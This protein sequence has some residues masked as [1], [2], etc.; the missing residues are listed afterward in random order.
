MTKNIYIIL[1]LLMTIIVSAQE[2]DTISTDSLFVVGVNWQ[3]LDDSG[4]DYRASITIDLNY[5]EFMNPVNKF[6]IVER[7]EF[8][9]YFLSTLDLSNYIGSVNSYVDENGDVQELIVLNYFIE[10]LDECVGD[11]CKDV[12]RAGYYGLPFYIQEASFQCDVNDNDKGGWYYKASYSDNDRVSFTRPSYEGITDPVLTVETAETPLGFI[13]YPAEIVRFNNIPVTCK[14]MTTTQ[15]SK[16]SFILEPN[17]LYRNNYPTIDGS[18]TWTYE[19]IINSLP[20]VSNREELPF[21]LDIG[22]NFSNAFW[23]YNRSFEELEARDD[24]LF[25][26]PDDY[27][28]ICEVDQ[29]FFGIPTGGIETLYYSELTIA[30]KKIINTGQGIFCRYPTSPGVS[31]LN[32]WTG[33]DV[34]NLISTENQRENLQKLEQLDKKLEVKEFFVKTLIP[35]IALLVLIVFYIIEIAI[36][37]IFALVVI[38]FTFKLFIDGLKDSFSLEDLKVKRGDD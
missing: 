4:D 37:G 21:S 18:E 3:R 26:S 2:Y 11:S 14:D 33:Y 22:F 5:G 10:L 35:S 36:I 8:D 1:F 17:P 25:G 24:N 34:D 29:T 27:D 6:A 15:N 23:D 32:S 16:L 12:P 7:Y 38:P 28:L 19:D 20:S 13:T 31:S 9:N 30:Q